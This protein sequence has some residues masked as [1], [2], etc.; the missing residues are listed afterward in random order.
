[1]ILKWKYT[2]EPIDVAVINEVEGLLNIKFPDDYIR[3]ALENHGG[4]V[5]PE[6]IDVDGVERVFGGLFS[7]DKESLENLVEHCKLYSEHTKLGYIPF[8]RDPGGNNF[9]F[10]FNESN[11]APIIVFWNHETDTFSK[12]ASTFTEFLSLLHD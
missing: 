4:S 12:I 1:M 10:D 2:D 5:T 3:V 9:Y 11:E 7:F 6:C 8:G